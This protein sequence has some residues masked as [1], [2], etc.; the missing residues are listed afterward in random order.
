M[1]KVTS[2]GWS[3]VE[4]RLLKRLNGLGAPAMTRA[5]NRVGQDVV[6]RYKQSISAGRSPAHKFPKLSPRYAK[7]KLKLYG[8]QP[9]LVA[10]GS[11]RDSL[12]YKVSSPGPN[13]YVLE[14]GAGGI[15]A[16][17]VSN[18][19]KAEWHIDGTPK[20]PKRDFGR[21]N[22]ALLRRSLTEALK[23]ELVAAPERV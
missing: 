2:Y 14:C 13:R 6:G 12:G 10:T 22:R 20:M 7:R 8:I 9:I 17:G 3:K 4:G 5:L 18:G 1:P 11:M 19:R 16:K 15:D 21:L 23:A